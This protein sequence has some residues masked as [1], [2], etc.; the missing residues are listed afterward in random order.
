MEHVYNDIKP[1]IAIIG[2][3]NVGKSTLFN[4]ILGSNAAIIDDRPGVTRDLNYRDMTYNDKPFTIIDTGGFYIDENQ[5]DVITKGIHEQI[6]SILEQVDGVLF[7]GDGVVGPHPSDYDIIDLIRKSGI[8]FWTAVSKIDA[9]GHDFR[10]ADFYQLGVDEVHGVSGTTG[11]GTYDL[12][13][14]LTKSFWTEKDIAEKAEKP[15]E[16][17]IRVAIIGR[18]N[19]GKSTLA[20]ALLGEER[21]LVSSVPGTTMDPIDSKVTHDEQNYLF[22]DTAGI[23]RKKMVLEV[24]EKAAVVRA[25]RAIDRSEVVVIMM[26]AQEPATDQDLR[27]L[28]MAHDKHRAIVIAINKWDTIEKET[29]TWETF[30]KDLRDRMK[31]APYAPMISMSAKENLRTTKVLSL[32]KEVHKNYHKHTADD[33]LQEWLNRSVR[34]NKPPLTKKRKPIIFFNVRME[35]VAPPTVVIKVNRPHSVHFSYHRYLMNQ[36]YKQFN[37]SGIAINVIYKREYFRP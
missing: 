24:M 13:D 3:P 32:I 2:R 25:F 30:V 37:Y 8:R 6:R 33:D 5:T 10:I 4:H 14:T 31:F 1:L 26:D 12:L 22:I 34:R 11:Y 16:D 15:E 36:F 27:I 21:H 29:G 18:P 23:R 7:L 9:D 19:V 17:V 28:G 35:S 20:N